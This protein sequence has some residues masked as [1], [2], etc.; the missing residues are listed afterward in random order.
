MQIYSRYS[1]TSGRS[2]RS[3]GTP[4]SVGELIQE[5]DMQT[6]VLKLVRVGSAYDLT[7]L[8]IDGKYVEASGLRTD[9]PM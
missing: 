6:Q 4:Q 1:F 7:R 2:G 8:S 9:F 5:T 3:L